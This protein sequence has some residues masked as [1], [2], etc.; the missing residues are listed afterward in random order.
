MSELSDKMFKSDFL[1]IYT[2]MESSG[3][4]K[5]V[6]HIEDA[7]DRLFWK[8][9][10]NT[11]CPNRYDIKP[12]SKP[13]SE[14]KRQLEKQYKHLN[15]DYLIA[16]DSDYDFL[17]PDRSEFSS[18]MNAN[19]F[20]LH[21]FC[22]SKESFIHTPE[23]IDDLT[24]CIHLHDKT[25]N[26]IQEALRIFSIIIYDALLVFSWLHNK[27]QQQFEESAFNASFMLPAGVYLLDDCLEVNESAL[28]NLRQS[29]KRYI[30]AHA[31]FIDDKESF[32]RHESAIRERGI[33]PENA[34]LFINGHDLLDGIFR[35][36]YE[37]FIRKSRKKDNEWVEANYPAQKVQSRKNQV[38]NHYE[39]NC[40]VHQLL[41]RCESYVA[42]T[43]WQKI[44][45]KLA[46][47]E[48]TA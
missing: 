44:T 30:D 22:Y 28:S 11:I 8:K 5:G 48:R 37:R 34:L 26:H 14:G 41:N 46:S 20:V 35:P 21:T 3:P 13:G 9:V 36:S 45:Q 23:N 15:K 38:R 24:D 42:S 4:Q 7:T 33:T 43:F 2:A 27:D 18:E 16:V 12:Y 32:E 25:H 47:A 31:D 40:R 19:P 1:K 29:V 17:C 6:I 10:V 39:D